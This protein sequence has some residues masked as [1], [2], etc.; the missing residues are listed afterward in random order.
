MKK[1]SSKKISKTQVKLC[2]LCGEETLV[3]TVHD[4][5][6]LCD[7]CMPNKEIKKIK[8][9]KSEADMLQTILTGEKVVQEKEV[10]LK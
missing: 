3:Y 6:P 7:D 5:A 2:N 4:N 10:N 9:I 8:K 1:A